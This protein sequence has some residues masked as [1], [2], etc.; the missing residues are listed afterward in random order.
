[1]MGTAM[2]TMLPANWLA[3]AIGSFVF[4]HLIKNRCETAA[5]LDYIHQATVSLTQ[6]TAILYCSFQEVNKAIALSFQTGDT[7]NLLQKVEDFVRGHK[8]FSEE[9]LNR[10]L[11]Q[12]D[13]NLRDLKIQEIEEWVVISRRCELDGS[14]SEFSV[15]GSKMNMNY[16]SSLELDKSEINEQKIK[17]VERKSPTKED[18]LRKP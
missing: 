4:L 3:S 16:I 9:I 14:T 12:N 1:M 7:E 13:I 8:E 6:F 18:G 11:E 17:Q 15:S 2:I 5:V 10:F